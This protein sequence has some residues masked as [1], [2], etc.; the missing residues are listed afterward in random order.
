MTVVDYKTGA[1]AKSAGEYLADVLDF[2]EFQLPF[3]YWA[4]TAAG[5]NVT[6]LSLVPP[7]GRALAE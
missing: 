6:R 4:R 1:I 2:S 5:D 3:Y 7:C